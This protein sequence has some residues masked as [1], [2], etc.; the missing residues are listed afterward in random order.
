ML[1]IYTF[2]LFTGEDKTYIG[3]AALSVPF[4]LIMCVC[5]AIGCRIHR[6]RQSGKYSF[7]T[8]ARVQ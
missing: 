6:C 3:F 7:H 2:L 8:A 1:T 4:I 5:V